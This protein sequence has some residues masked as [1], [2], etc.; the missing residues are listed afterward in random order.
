MLNCM[1]SGIPILM[2]GWIDFGLNEVLKEVPGVYLA[3]DFSHL[4]SRLLEW[5]DEPPQ[6]AEQAAEYFVRSPE[7]GRDAFCLLVEDLMTGQQSRKE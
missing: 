4:E 2:P 7:A 6:V 3:H 1:A 5:I